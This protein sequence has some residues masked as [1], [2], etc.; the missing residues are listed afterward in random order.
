M[1]T[2]P[3]TMF[4]TLKKASLVK[5]LGALL[6]GTPCGARKISGVHREGGI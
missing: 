6:Y 1:D 2:E 3:V 5:R 4:D